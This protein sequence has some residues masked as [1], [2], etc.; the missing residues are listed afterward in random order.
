MTGGIIVYVSV[1][2]ATVQMF[3]F[4]KLYTL[5]KK[6]YIKKVCNKNNLSLLPNAFG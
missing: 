6:K 2:T 1:H 4:G 5:E 3:W